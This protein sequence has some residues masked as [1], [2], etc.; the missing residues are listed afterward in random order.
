M[1]QHFKLWNFN[2]KKHRRKRE[3]KKAHSIEKT[4][5]L[6]KNFIK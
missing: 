5:P 1:I 2:A 6:R 3:E 4:V